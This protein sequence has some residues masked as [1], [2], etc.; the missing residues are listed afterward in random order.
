[1]D[2]ENKLGYNDNLP[3]GYR[4]NKYDYEDY[5]GWLDRHREDLEEAFFIKYGIDW[6]EDLVEWEKFVRNRW[7]HGY[8]ED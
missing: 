4:P 5:D 7:V 1:M 2:R 6:E 3:D 8:Y